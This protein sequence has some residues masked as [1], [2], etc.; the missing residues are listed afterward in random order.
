MNRN[1]LERHFNQHSST[2]RPL[3]S[4][5]SFV[6]YPVSCSAPFSLQYCQAV[7]YQAAWREAEA[8]QRPSLPERDLLGVWN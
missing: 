5:C 1:R 4:A 2:P 3:V 8:I 7:V 6:L